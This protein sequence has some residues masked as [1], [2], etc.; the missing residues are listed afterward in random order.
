MDSSFNIFGSSSAHFA[1]WFDRRQEG[2]SHPCPRLADLE[3][4]INTNEP[5][6][7][8][9]RP[10][11]PGEHHPLQRPEHGWQQ[12]S[13][14]TRLRRRVRAPGLQGGGFVEVVGRV[15]S[16]GGT[17]AIIMRIAAGCDRPLAQVAESCLCSELDAFSPALES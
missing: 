17:E 14:W 15:P 5:N 16:P 1:F 11:L 13:L 6:G 3:P 12:F 9:A 2:S 4:R 8:W 10:M 7:H